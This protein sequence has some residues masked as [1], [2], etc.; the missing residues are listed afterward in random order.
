MGI[1]RT[2]ARLIPYATVF[3]LGYYAGTIESGKH[4]RVFCE[5]PRV[6]E[7]YAPGGTLEARLNSLLEDEQLFTLR[8]ENMLREEE[9]VM[10]YA[11]E[12]RQD[13][14]P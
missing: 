14:Y 13:A 4:D 8:D 2:A 3:L 1:I 5:K 9:G 6:Q 10:V 12:A 11:R 7:E